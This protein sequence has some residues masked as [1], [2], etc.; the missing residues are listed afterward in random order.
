MKAYILHKHKQTE[1]KS[2]IGPFIGSM[3]FSPSKIK[4]KLVAYVTE[5]FGVS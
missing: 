2:S 4:E 1:K 3:L 5:R